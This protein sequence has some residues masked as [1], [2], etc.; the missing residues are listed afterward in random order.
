MCDLISDSTTDANVI[1]VSN[2]MT[3]ARNASATAIMSTGVGLSLW[4]IYA[5]SMRNIPN[6]IVTTTFHILK[7][8]SKNIHKNQISKKN[9]NMTKKIS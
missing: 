7:N 8:L 6:K 2:D 5:V 1:V 3:I 9:I 4:T